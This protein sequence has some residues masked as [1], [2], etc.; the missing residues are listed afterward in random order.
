MS[1]A[2][3]LPR[4]NLKMAKNLGLPNIPNDVQLKE[5]IDNTANIVAL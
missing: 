1:F 2:F 3:L 5:L 4:L